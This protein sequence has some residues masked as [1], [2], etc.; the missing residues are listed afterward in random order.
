MDPV[1]RLAALTTVMVGGVVSVATADGVR[2]RTRLLPASAIQM[3]PFAPMPMPAGPF[4]CAERAAPPSPENPAAPVPA[5]VLSAPDVVHWRIRFA[6]V[7]AISRLPSGAKAMP[8][9]ECS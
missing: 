5:M 1:A 2:D 6:P 4:N 8:V 7:S 3:V 9:G